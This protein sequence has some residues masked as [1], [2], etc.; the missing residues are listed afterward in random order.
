M[1]GGLRNRNSFI[2]NELM[3][4]GGVS[5]AQIEVIAQEIENLNFDEDE[6]LREYVARLPSNIHDLVKRFT[7]TCYHMV[8]TGVVQCETGTDL[9]PLSEFK[10]ADVIL[11]ARDA[12]AELLSEDAVFLE[13]FMGFALDTIQASVMPSAII[14]S[15]SFTMAHQLSEALREQGF[16][17]TYDEIVSAYASSLSR[18]EARE[19]LESFDQEAVANK[20]IELAKVFKKKIIDELPNYKTAIQS[21]T[22]DEAYRVGTDIALE[23]GK[24]IPVIGTFIHFADIIKR[25]SEASIGAVDKWSVRNQNQA[26]IEAQKRRTERIRSAIE[27]LK[28]SSQ[29]KSKLLNAVASLSDIHGLII[30]RA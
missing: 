21:E 23:G 20:A 5:A 27:R 12:R 13:A 2:A 28:A 18:D 7:T 6:P 17:K 22:T 16:Q 24:L 3:N 9:S 11:A 26:F 1:V 29:T 25:L 8:G 14:D 19:A 4:T 15:M 10:A 30:R